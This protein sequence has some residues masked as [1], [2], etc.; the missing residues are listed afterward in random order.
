[1][2]V[3]SLPPY[4][5]LSSPLFFPF[6]HHLSPQSSAQ[7]LPILRP[8]PRKQLLA[9]RRLGPAQ[10]PVPPLLNQPAVARHGRARAAPDLH[11]PQRRMGRDGALGDQIQGLAGGRLH[12][13][14]CCGCWRGLEQGCGGAEDGRAGGEGW[15]EGGEVGEGAFRLLLACWVRQKGWEGFAYRVAVGVVF[16]VVGTQRGRIWAVGRRSAAC[17]SGDC[18]ASRDMVVRFRVFFALLAVK[19]NSLSRCR[20]RR[21]RDRSV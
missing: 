19:T 15:A 11:V 14:C 7:P 13:C 9:I 20:D 2:Y 3:A 8:P 18:M 5:T 17:K 1:M 16:A 10:K 6:L 12:R 4:Y 21:R